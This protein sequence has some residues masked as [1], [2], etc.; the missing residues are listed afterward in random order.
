[1]GGIFGSE[2][3]LWQAWDN[4]IAYIRNNV[5]EGT[6]S[7]DSYVGGVL[8]YYR[9]LNRYTVIENNRCTGECGAERG[10][11]AVLYVDSS[12]Y[13]DGSNKPAGWKTLS[14]WPEKVY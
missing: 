14:G 7:G 11:G 4:G 2:G 1:M 10:I 3:G 8:G 9:S 6:V 12:K 13:S 5:F